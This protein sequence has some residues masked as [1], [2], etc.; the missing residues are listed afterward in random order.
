[1]GVLISMLNYIGPT[2]R[3]NLERITGQCHLS[4][5]AT[6]VAKHK[7]AL[8]KFAPQLTNLRSLKMIARFIE[9]ELDKTGDDMHPLCV[10]RG[11]KLQYGDIELSD[12]PVLEARIS[13]FHHK[14]VAHVAQPN[15][16]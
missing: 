6:T 4:L 14:M 5:A 3:A 9:T 1:M 15:I 16:N 10:L 11:V 13:A 7:R 2:S 8:R 12:H